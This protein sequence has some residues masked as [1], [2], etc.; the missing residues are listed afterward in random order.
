MDP[1]GTI[2]SPP[3]SLSNIVRA[4]L[5]RRESEDRNNCLRPQVEPDEIIADNLRATLT[6]EM[7]YSTTVRHTVD[8]I[9]L[10][11]ISLNLDRG[12]AAAG[13]GAAVS[14]PNGQ[15][16][17]GK[18]VEDIIE[19]L[20]LIKKELGILN[21][22]DAEI[23]REGD[24]LEKII[25]PLS[26]LKEALGDEADDADVTRCLQGAI[27]AAHMKIR[28]TNISE[29]IHEYQTQYHKVR[30]LQKSYLEAVQ[31]LKPSRPTCNIC[32][33]NEINQVLIPCGHALCSNCV[34]QSLMRARDQR[35]KC[36][37]CRTTV[38]KTCKL[39]L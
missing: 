12:G 4:S 11:G 2:L 35:R 25:G 10:L 18:I 31:I 39:H 5:S 16:P 20:D 33:T 26:A 37:Y 17:G 24:K 32:L 34:N 8:R 1:F 9:Q 27:D 7:G 36:Y 3:G 13:G 21:D 29:K 23:T 22:L 6:M 28:G 19:F 15:T 38:E 14:T 30:S